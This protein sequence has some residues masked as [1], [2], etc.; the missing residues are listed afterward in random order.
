VSCRLACGVFNF[1][2]TIMV[3]GCSVKVVVA[4]VGVVGVVE[5]MADVTDETVWVLYHRTINLY[6]SCAEPGWLAQE[7][8]GFRLVPASE[9]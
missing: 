4:V 8:L 5:I 1:S 3:L 6:R 9:E 7:T 2:G